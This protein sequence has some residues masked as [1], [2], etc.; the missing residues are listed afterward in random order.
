MRRQAFK[1]DEKFTYG[2]YLHLPDDGKRYQVIDGELLM[3][4]APVPYHQMISVN[5]ERLLYD[6][7]RNEGGRVLHAPCDVVLTDIDIVQP[8]V[9]FI[10]KDR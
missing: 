9:F 8:D 3:V 1:I 4:P 10:S 7:A 5:I 2:D 6:H